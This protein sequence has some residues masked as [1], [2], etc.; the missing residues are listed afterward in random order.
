MALPSNAR[1]VPPAGADDLV[2]PRATAHAVIFLAPNH[3]PVGH[4]TSSVRRFPPLAGSEIVAETFRMTMLPGQFPH[5]SPKGISSA[6]PRLPCRTDLLF[7]PS[8]ESFTL[9]LAR[10]LRQGIPVP[11][12]F[13]LS[14]LLEGYKR[15]RPSISIPPNNARLSAGP[16]WCQMPMTELPA[17]LEAQDTPE[18]GH[19]IPAVPPVSTFHIRRRRST[20]SNLSERRA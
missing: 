20:V 14:V 5:S 10:A 12:E 15:V 8:G 9:C 2:A 13:L 17:Q 16:R 4:L 11:P 18:L 19:T 7:N 3:D 6:L 1:P